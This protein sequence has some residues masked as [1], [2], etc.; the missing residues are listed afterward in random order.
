M[1]MHLAQKHMERNTND[2][3]DLP[4]RKAKIAPKHRLQ[5]LL[6]QRN[7]AHAMIREQHMRSDNVTSKAKTLTLESVMLWKNQ[8]KPDHLNYV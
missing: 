1:P 4:E 7:A 5:I 2:N 8:P 3:A 6:R